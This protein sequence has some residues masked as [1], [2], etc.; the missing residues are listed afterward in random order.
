MLVWRPVRSAVDDQGTQD[1]V[2]DTMPGEHLGLFWWEKKHQV[3]SPAAANE[4]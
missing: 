3:F 4:T 2:A 1:P